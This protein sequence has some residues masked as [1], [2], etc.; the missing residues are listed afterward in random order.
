M[1]KSGFTLTEALIT[2]GIIGVVAALTRPALVKQSAD[3]ANAAKLSVTVSNL[4]NGLTTMIMKENAVDIM[5]TKAWK[6]LSGVSWDKLE[7]PNEWEVT[8]NAQKLTGKSSQA[9]IDAFTGLLGQYIHVR[10]AKPIAKMSTYYDSKGPYALQS[11]GS[12]GSLYSSLDGEVFAM[13]LKNGATVFA[14]VF[15][16]GDNLRRTT[17]AEID[18]LVK[19]GGAYTHNMADIF[20]D[21]NGKS[22]PNTIGRD[23][24]A[25]QIGENGV[26]YP[27]G[28]KALQVYESKSSDP[29]LW[30][31]TSA[32][33]ACLPE[34]KIVK[35]SGWGCTARLVEEGYKFSY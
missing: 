25:F 18:D 16:N 27:S 9:D 4:E 24:F 8:N 1:K 33:S 3:D 5:G 15:S 20:I 29:G 26:L 30:N 31:G 13:E 2:L 7:E 11:D 28:G 10:G 34:S 35:N 12:K 6:F 17:Q 19:A 23:L 14:R 21:V 22:A 32:D